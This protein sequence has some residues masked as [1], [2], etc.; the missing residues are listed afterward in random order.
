M[1]KAE[2]AIRGLVELADIEINGS[3]P[4]D[5][6][7]NDSRFYQQMLS[8]GALGF[9]ETYMQG[10]W[11][12]EALDGL[13]Y[14]L[15]RA[16]LEHRISPLKLLWPVL[17]SK[18]VN[19]QSRNRA[20][21]IGEHHYDLGNAL[22]QH[23]LDPRMT[24]TCGYWK[25]ADNLDDAQE[26]KLDLVCRKIGLEPGMRVLDIGCGWG[27]FAG[28]AAE[29]Y[30]V[31]VVGVTVSKEQIALGQERYKELDVDLRFQDY[32]DVNER[33]DRVV[34]IGMF[35]HVGSKN[36][37]TFMKVVESCLEDEGLFL[38]HTIGTNT[39]ATAVDPW[40]SKY[41]FPGGMLPVPEQIYAAANGI[42]IMEDMQNIGTHYDPTLMAWM[43]NIDTNREALEQLGYDQRFYR[44]WRYFL[45]SSAG[46]ARARRN[47]LWQIVYSKKGLDG[48]YT[49]IH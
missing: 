14:H 26:A 37:R 45:L 44:M 32:R 40:T 1:N 6:Q 28:F 16:D 9:G 48:G 18:F 43:D 25:D 27:S 33:F 3:R 19:L 13:I 24:Y 7:V 41:I 39:K 2:V 20:F 17:W 21:R 34:S 10:L 47:Q 30:G 4:H 11:D 49:P 15:L 12:C 35:E 22:Y 23:M 8:G 46:S 42:F 31:K 29:R 38:L 36:Y 5:I